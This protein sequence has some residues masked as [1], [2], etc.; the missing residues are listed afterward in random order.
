MKIYLVELIIEAG[1]SSTSSTKF[2]IFSSSPYQ[3]KKSIIVPLYVL[4]KLINTNIT[5]NSEGVFR[6]KLEVEIFEPPPLPP[7]PPSSSRAFDE[8][9]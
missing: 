5:R 4:S 1:D 3:E 9:I 6:F 2:F 8:N 7:D